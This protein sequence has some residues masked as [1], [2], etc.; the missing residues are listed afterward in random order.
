MESLRDKAYRL[1]HERIITC[2]MMPGDMVDEKTLIQETGCGRTP[3]RE[4]LMILAKDGLVRIVPRRGI[5]I[6]D[7]TVKDVRDILELKRELEPIIVRQYGG[8]IPR[9]KLRYFQEHFRTEQD[10]FHYTLAD[11]EFHAIFMEVCDNSY[12]KLIMNIVSDQS[13]RIRILTNEAHERLEQSSKEHLD[14]VDALLE[15]DVD[16]AA[17]RMR[18]HYQHSL[19]DVL[20]FRLQDTMVAL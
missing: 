17:E 11:A 14:I 1:I 10:A 18:I 9:E 4:A 5:F 7:I 16:L 3:V 2:Q 8:K 19:E 13:Q 15:G 12:Y 6:S 20:R